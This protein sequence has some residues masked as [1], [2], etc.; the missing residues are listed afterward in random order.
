MRV[1]E[2]RITDVYVDPIYHEAN[3]F[4]VFLAHSLMSQEMMSK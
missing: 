2:R 1:L 3:I 4:T